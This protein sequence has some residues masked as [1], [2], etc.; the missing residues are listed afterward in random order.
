M[1]V[2]TRNV[3]VR[4][5]SAAIANIGWDEAMRSVVKRWWP[6]VPRSKPRSSASTTISKLRAQRVRQSRP[7]GPVSRG[8]PVSVGRGGPNFTRE[9]P[10]L[11]DGGYRMGQGIGSCVTVE[12][13]QSVT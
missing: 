5:A 4:A 10:G 12:T 11:F 2:R 6:T 9:F 13:D 8:K 7:R 1:F 3:V